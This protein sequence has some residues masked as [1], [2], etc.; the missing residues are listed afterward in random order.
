MTQDWKAQLRK[1]AARRQKAD[2]AA[3]AALAALYD[4]IDA[5]QAAGATYQE[6]AD[7]VGVSRIRVGQVLKDRRA[8]AA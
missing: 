8:Q 1:A 3:E 6:I 5:A 4:A 7:V 2:D